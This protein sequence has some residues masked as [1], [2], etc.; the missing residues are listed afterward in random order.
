MMMKIL[1]IL[2][3]TLLLMILFLEH[4]TDQAELKSMLLFAKNY[5]HEFSD[6]NTYNAEI[7]HATKL[8]ENLFSDAERT[9]SLIKV[10]ETTLLKASSF[11][12]V[13][14][15]CITFLPSLLNSL[16]NRVSKCLASPAFRISI[17]AILFW[18]L[19]FELCIRPGMLL[20][21]AQVAIQTAI[22]KHI[23]GRA[24]LVYDQRR[25]EVEESH[26]GM[27]CY[28]L[29][30][31][32]ELS[33]LLWC[34][35]F[36]CDTGCMS[37]IEASDNNGKK[38]TLNLELP[39]SYDN[40]STTIKKSSGQIFDS[41]IS[42]IPRR[43]FILWFGKPMTGARLESYTHLRARFESAGIE[44]VLIN[45]ENY[46]SFEVADHPIHPTVIKSIP[47]TPN[48]GLSM[49][50]VGDY[51][52]VY[53]MHFHGGGYTDVKKNLDRD[54]VTGAQ[55][56]WKGAFDEF[57]TDKEL[58][59]K[60]TTEYG[61]SDAGCDE[62]YILGDD[63]CDKL[64]GFRGLDSNSIAGEYLL[65]DQLASTN[66]SN[67]I[68]SSAVT[69]SMKALDLKLDTKKARISLDLPVKYWSIQASNANCCKM[70]RDSWEKLVTNCMYILRPKTPLTAEWLWSVEAHLTLKSELVFQNPAPKP[71]CCQGNVEK[72]AE[73]AAENAYPIDWAELHGN[74]F[75]PL[76][77]KYN[78]HVKNGLP[79]F[80]IANYLGE[81]EL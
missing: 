57:D 38:R 29:R 45:E 55:F 34:Y 48:K 78:E 11:L 40:N 65:N 24:N 64:R 42:P 20:S 19:I 60:G 37:S 59:V 26:Y 51:L 33:H 12:F 77:W 49:I 75:N 71:R 25:I 68:S 31:V 81:G 47:F 52:R 30:I 13:L 14:L 50:H 36:C 43:F 67:T 9:L 58:W 39:T 32:L 15:I 22:D 5:L 6:Q 4:N 56:D 53:L 8:I 16:R 74:A 3:S 35:Y 80:D 41:V 70:V 44:I 76:Q 69:S 27:F 66:T 28:T 79:R 72:N 62:S 54:E 18:F 46:K 23:V 73:T 2:A 63:R 10:M 7:R 1:L 21:Q 17:A 61:W